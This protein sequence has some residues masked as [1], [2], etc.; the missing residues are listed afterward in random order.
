MTSTNDDAMA[1]RPKLPC[2]VCHDYFVEGDLHWLGGRPFCGEHHE[3]A[4]DASETNWMRAGL[5]EAALLVLFVVGVSFALGNRA[6]PTEGIAA[7]GLALVPAA[8]WLVFIYRQD[9]VEPEPIGV[10]LGVFVLGGLI[11]HALGE[12]LTAALLDVDTWQHHSDLSAWI[13]SIAVEGTV[14]VFAAFLAVRYSV[15]LT[16]EFDEA[17]DGVIYATAASLGVAT[18]Q[19]F[20]LL[21]HHPQMVPVVGATAMATTALVGVAAGVILGYGL[22]RRRFSAE[23][24]HRWLTICFVVAAVVHGSMHEVVVRVDTAAGEH[25]PRIGFAV[26][27][28]LAVLVLSAVHVLSAAYARDV[29]ERGF[30]VAGTD[31]DEDEGELRLEGAS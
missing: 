10:V 23:G 27:T 18:S 4:L 12:P 31:E 22:G 21:T 7:L 29:L 16:S 5:L 6:L 26:A 9:R 17:I 25:D 14:A 8:L 30:D 13:G 11:E 3:R 24:G 19:N 1:P 20:D 15:Y 28:G 2:C